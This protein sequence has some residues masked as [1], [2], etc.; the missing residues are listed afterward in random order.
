[1]DNIICKEE[2][3]LD[4]LLHRL[5]PTD[6]F[7]SRTICFPLKKCDELEERIKTMRFYGV[8]GLLNYG[9][10]VID[11]DI[12][13]IGKGY[14][15]IVVLSCIDDNY[16]PIVLKIRRLD[17][18]RKSLEYEGIILD[19]LTPSNY[20]PALYFW[21]KDFI[22]MEYVTGLSL[23]KYIEQT[24]TSNNASLL[25]MLVRII[26]SSYFFDLIGVDHTELNR[27][28]GHV[29]VTRKNYPVYLDWESAKI[30]RKPHNLTMI[31]SYLFIRSRHSE[32]ILELLN[33]EKETIIPH[34]RMYKFNPTKEYLWLIKLVRGAYQRLV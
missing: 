20:T 6:P 13:V 31:A 12:R 3:L 24:I 14:S 26:S 11:K 25:R 9:R 30:R 33:I 23:E 27:P 8:K 5:D 16:K 7:I 10:V 18:R 4:G 34:L 1:M 22:A 19:Y 21:S 32:K 29:L 15:S 2:A 17:S 28:Y